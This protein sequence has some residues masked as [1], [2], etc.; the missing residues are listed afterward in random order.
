MLQGG[1]YWSEGPSAVTFKYGSS[2]TELLLEVTAAAREGR[3]LRVSLGQHSQVVISCNFI[4]LNTLRPAWTHKAT[5]PTELESINHTLEK[6]RHH[7]W[8]FRWLTFPKDILSIWKVWQ[9]EIQH[10]TPG[11]PSCK[12]TVD[13]T[14]THAYWGLLVTY[15]VQTFKKKHDYVFF[16]HFLWWDG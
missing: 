1:Q 3:K 4:S 16:E 15:R 2:T 7:W 5:L 9:V 12:H 6:Y 13:F 11:V 14:N 10:V 8:R